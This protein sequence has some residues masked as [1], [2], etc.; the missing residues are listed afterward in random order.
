MNHKLIIFPMKTKIIFLMMIL[1]A[2]L[3]AED[4][5]NLPKNGIDPALIHDMNSLSLD[6]LSD[7]PQEAI[8]NSKQALQ[9][10]TKIGSKK[11]QCNSLKIIGQAYLTIKNYTEAETYLQQA[12]QISNQ[13]DEN[14]Y[15]LEILKYLSVVKSE[16]GHPQKAL[17]YLSGSLKIAESKNDK[18]EIANLMNMM[19]D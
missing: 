17:D 6:Y 14:E 3:Q 7:T 9:L 19:G 2:F 1:L 10:A 11:E 15:R 8:Y 12:L 4:K 13:I 16:T 5:L 18:I